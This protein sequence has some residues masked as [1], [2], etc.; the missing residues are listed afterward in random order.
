M[1][2]P[3]FLASILILSLLG[4]CAPRTAPRRPA[5]APAPTR[6]L[7]ADTRT[8]AP[9]YGGER[10]KR[11]GLHPDLF[12][13]YAPTLVAATPTA[14]PTPEM[15]PPGEADGSAT[16][17]E[18]APW[19]APQGESLQ[20]LIAS[21]TAPNVV[22]ALRLVEQGRLQ[23]E[24]GRNETAIDLFERAVAIDPANAQGYY[25]LGVLHFGQG[26]YSQALAFANRAVVLASSGD[27]TWASRTY[28][29]QATVL[30]KVGRYPDARSAYSRALDLD[31]GNVSA[32][33]GL[34]RLGG[35]SDVSDAP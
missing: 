15:T 4:A 22:A 24:S 2:T 14:S 33:V 29:L 5:S 12:E 31:P 32:R 7:S 26:T 25:Y 21:A 6:V 8:P 10:P 17:E 9:S 23:L 27:R 3:R 34:S 28:L 1:H 18:A 30:E 19:R 11:T 13:D 16:G 35:T 20:P